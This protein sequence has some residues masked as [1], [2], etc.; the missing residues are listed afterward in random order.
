LLKRPAYMMT[1]DEVFDINHD[2][3]VKSLLVTFNVASSKQSVEKYKNS[4]EKK[5]Q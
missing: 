4:S 5:Q 2:F 3:C 1:V